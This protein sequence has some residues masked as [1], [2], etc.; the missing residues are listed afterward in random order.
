[1]IS[2]NNIG[3]SFSG[4]VLFE[5]ISFLINISDRIGLVGKNGAGKT[6]ILKI[7]AGKLAANSGEIVTPSGMAYGYLPQ[8]M[9]IVSSRSILDETL[10]TFSEIRQIEKN[11]KNLT[12]Q[13]ENRTDFDSPKYLELIDNLAHENE[14]YQIHGGSSAQADVEKVLKGLGFSQNDLTRSITE[15]SNGWQ[16]RVELAKILLRQPACLLLDE[17]TN[18]LDIESIQW[19]EDY[20]IN[21]PGALM[22][23]SHDRAFLDNVTKRTIEINQGKIYDYKASY[24][25]Y[26]RL[27]EER[28]DQQTST[29]NNQQK[30]IKEVEKFIE[31]FRY[32]STKSKQVQSRIKSLDKMDKIEIEEIDKSSIH[33]RFPPAPAAGK[34]VVEARN[35]SKHYGSKMVLDK[36]NFMALSGEKIAFVGKNGEGKTT[37][38]KIIGNTL[39]YEGELKAGYNVTMGYYAQNQWEMLNPEL[40]VF[41]TVDEVAIGDIRARLRTLLGSFLFSGEAID[42]KVKVLSGGEKSRLSLAKLLLS[43]VNLLILDEPT[44]HLDMRSKDILKNALLMYEGALI[45]VSHDRDFLQGLTTRVIEFKNKTIKE[46]LGDIYYF[47][48]KKKLEDL[49]QLNEASK[50]TQLKEKTLSD[51]KLKYEQKKE[52]EREIRKINTQI[53]KSESSIELIEKEIETMDQKLASPDQYQEEINSGELYKNYDILKK[54]LNQEMKRWEELQYELEV[55]QSNL[56]ST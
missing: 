6:T 34:I 43:P 3:L 39:D 33:F 27:R 9:K 37:F 44:N 51:N 17:P 53:T 5:N 32:K 4:N 11:I 56:E 20:L 40:T 50:N 14:N 30:Q 1:M 10:T 29:Y 28:L 46:Y 18:H 48:E 54:K 36:I 2:V 45:I 23:V 41:E 22:L 15:F 25:D 8:E 31:R 49:S 12:S 13:I 42:K 21:Y 47:L 26:V 7:I 19:L 38:A 35:L 55:V 24:S 52:F 16:M